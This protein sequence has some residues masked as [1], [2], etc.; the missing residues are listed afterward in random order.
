M[1]G[2]IDTARIEGMEQ[3]IQQGQRSLLLNLL[4]RKLGSIPLP[5]IEKLNQIE[6]S[7]L[8][9]LSEALFDLEDLEALD[10]WVR[11]HRPGD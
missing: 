8:E 3:G 5:I 1:Q 10:R 4:S 2:V 9:A 6:S 7:K 11:E